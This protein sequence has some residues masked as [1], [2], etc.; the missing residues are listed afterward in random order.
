MATKCPV[1]LEA[2]LE[3]CNMVLQVGYQFGNANRKPLMTYSIVIALFL[4]YQRALRLHLVTD[5]Q[6]TKHCML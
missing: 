2:L 3:P 6:G 4:A 5:K 1:N